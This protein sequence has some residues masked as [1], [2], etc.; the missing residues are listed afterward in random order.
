VAGFGE[1]S[2]D[3]MAARLILPRARFTL[4]IFRNGHL[5]MPCCLQ[6]RFIVVGHTAERRVSVT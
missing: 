4:L 1:Q 6:M 2:T 5:D 3:S